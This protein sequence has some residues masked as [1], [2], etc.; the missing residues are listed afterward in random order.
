MRSE[1]RVVDKKYLIIPFLLT[2]FE[3]GPIQ[4]M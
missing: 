2:K 1:I 3:L 4:P